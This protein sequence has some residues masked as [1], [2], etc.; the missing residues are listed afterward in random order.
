MNKIIVDLIY[1]PIPLRCFD[2]VAYRDPESYSGYGASADEAI[3]DLLETE[4]SYAEDDDPTPYECECGA[5]FE[6]PTSVI[7]CME[8]HHGE[9]C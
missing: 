8:N 1:P 5:R 6:E 4:A 7:C 3:I 9:S 2:Y